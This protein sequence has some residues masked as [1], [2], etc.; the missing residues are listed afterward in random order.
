MATQA[1][2]TEAQETIIRLTHAA[3]D[4]TPEGMVIFGGVLDPESLPY[5]KEDDYQREAQS[6]H[7][8]S[9]LIEAMRQ[10][11]IPP[12]IELGMRG[13][14]YN[15]INPTTIE[16]YDPVYIVD[17]LQR[18]TAARF[19]L[20]QDDELD[21]IHLRA[22][23]YLN[24]SNQWERDR[25]QVLN[26]ARTRVSS[27]IHLRNLG[28]N[29]SAIR[30]LYQMTSSQTRSDFVMSGRVQWEQS[31][32]EQEIISAHTLVKVVAQL[33]S[34]L[35]AVKGNKPEILAAGLQ[36]VYDKIGHNAFRDNVRLFFETID[37]C[38]SIRTIMKKDTVS[39]MKLSFMEQLARMFSEHTDF[40][41]AR[42]SNKLFINVTDLKKLKIFP[43][44]DN[45]VAQWSN[46]GGPAREALFMFMTNHMNKGRRT[47]FLTPRL[48]TFPPEVDDNSDEDE[49]TE[50]VEERE[51]AVAGA[52]R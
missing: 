27:N 19:M 38:W 26:T 12:E 44:Y 35:G 51:P 37:H 25:F 3:M 11:K 7:S 49:E 46:S 52:R 14:S 42:N 17:G 31:M 2:A 33:M 28:K 13:E 32:K 43:V 9:D 20:M 50:E 45:T 47:G 23:V 39:F 41:D 29:S 18:V 8:L 24:T 5:L 40:W 10:G 1:Q 48:V 16:L 34:H 6:P 4:T 21:K 22:T 15:A 30:L 36:R